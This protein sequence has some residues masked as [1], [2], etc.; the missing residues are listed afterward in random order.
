M[1]PCRL[2]ADMAKQKSKVPVQVWDLAMGRAVRELRGHT[3][4]ITNLAW[5]ADSR[6][7]Y[8]LLPLIFKL[9]NN[10]DENS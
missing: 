4:T 9:I 5:G 10:A 1:W 2:K 6:H 3:D 8:S 7:F